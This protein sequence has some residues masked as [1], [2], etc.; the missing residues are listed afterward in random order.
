MLILA[1]EHRALGVRPFTETPEA[2]VAAEVA[3]WSAGLV[4]GAPDVGRRL[5]MQ[6][7][8]AIPGWRPARPPCPGLDGARRSVTAAHQP[9]AG[10]AGR[11]REDVGFVNVA[12][13]AGA[14]GRARLVRRPRL[15]HGEDALRPDSLP[16][17]ARHTAAVLAARLGLSRR[18][19]VL[20]LDNTLWGGVIG[21]DGVGGIVL[22]GGTAGEAFQDFQVALKELTG[23]G[24]VLAVCSKNDR[25]VALRAVPRAPRD[26]AEGGGHRRLRRQLGAEVEEHP[27]RSPRPSASG[28]RASPSSTTTP[29][30]GPRCAGR[31]RRSTCR[32]C[33]RT[34]P[35]SARRWRTIPTS[36]RRPSPRPTATAPSQYRARARASR[37][38]ATAASSL[39][40]YQASLEHGGADR[41]RSTRLN[42]ARVVQLINKTNQ[43]NLTTRRRNRAELEAF[44]ARPG[45]DGLRVRLADRFADHGLIAVALAAPARRPRSRST[46]S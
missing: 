26:G 14:H 18:A 39:E 23:R 5:I 20:D 28:S 7:G 11:R 1:P 3:R 22:G 10:A 12:L 29:T 9:R 38:R 42:M 36:S 2:D 4:G 40:E 34:R 17:M 24:I 21:D 30:S 32:S 19:L 6:M 13:L 16:V 45:A 27:R 44:L 25:E 8:F 31:C 35:A 33:R 37:A 41:P 15:V 43:F 46:R